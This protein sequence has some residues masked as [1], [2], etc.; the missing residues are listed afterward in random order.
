MKETCSLSAK[1]EGHKCLVYILKLVL[2]LFP[3]RAVR[4]HC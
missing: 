4:Q 2:E 1:Y 3:G